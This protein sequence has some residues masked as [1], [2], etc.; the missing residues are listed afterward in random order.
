[1]GEKVLLSTGPSVLTQELI[2]PWLFLYCF[3]IMNYKENEVFPST[4]CHPYPI[5]PVYI[6]HVFPDTTTCKLRV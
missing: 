3:F 1:M 2:V 6:K 5:G 4:L